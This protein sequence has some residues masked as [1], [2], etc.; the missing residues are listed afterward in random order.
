[1]YVI[2]LHVVIMFLFLWIV[3]LKSDEDEHT[4]CKCALHLGTNSLMVWARP[5]GSC[6][7]AWNKVR[8]ISCGKNIV[9]HGMSTWVHLFAVVTDMPTTPVPTTTTGQHVLYIS[10]FCGPLLL[11]LYH[12][13]VISPPPFHQIY[14]ILTVGIIA[15]ILQWRWYLL[16]EYGGKNVFVMHKFGSWWTNFWLSLKLVCFIVLVL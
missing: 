16:T 15:T 9:D 3:W 7:C 11:L 2:V 14:T 1:M 13:D 12:E 6:A 10:H 8:A 4:A 5:N